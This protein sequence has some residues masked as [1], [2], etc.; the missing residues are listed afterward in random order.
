MGCTRTYKYSSRFSFIF[1]MLVGACAV[2]VGDG[3]ILNRRTGTP[4]YRDFVYE[5]L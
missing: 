3:V 2:V 4:L 1:D 5:E